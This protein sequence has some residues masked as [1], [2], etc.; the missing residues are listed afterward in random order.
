MLQQPQYKINLTDTVLLI[1]DPQKAF[2]EIIPVPNYEPAL[3]NILSLSKAWKNAGGKVIVT[4]HVYKNK[5]EVGRIIN[6]L[7][8]VGDLLKDDSP[9]ANFHDGI[10][11]DTVISKSRFNALLGTDLEVRSD[12]GGPRS[13]QGRGVAHW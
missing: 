5:A 9:N 2:G 7:P 4:R 11:V 13:E 10:S 8:G 6:F 12:L 1:I 3:R